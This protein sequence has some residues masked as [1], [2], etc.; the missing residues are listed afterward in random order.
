[1]ASPRGQPYHL[2]PFPAIPYG[3]AYFKGIRQ[4]GCLYVDKT[5]FLHPLEQ[6]RFVF[7]VRPRRFGKL[8]RP[9]PG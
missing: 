4:D 2:P 7:F 1:M 9:Q 3:R 8:L 5:R 6:E